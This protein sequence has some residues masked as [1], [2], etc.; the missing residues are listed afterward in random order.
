MNVSLRFWLFSLNFANIFSYVYPYFINNMNTFTWGFMICI[1]ISVFLN[2]YRCFIYYNNYQSLNI[3][4][5]ITYTFAFTCSTFLMIM[6]NYNKFNMSFFNYF[7]TIII[8]TLTY[9][10]TNSYKIINFQDIS[11]SSS[12][13]EC[14]I[15]LES[16]N[17]NFVKTSCNHSYHERCI[18]QW[19]TIKPNCPICREEF[20]I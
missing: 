8:N 13:I 7:F 2:F 14:V 20:K 11:Q 10:K 18:T 16:D 3:F 17:K 1:I 9:F 12:N 6:L 4:Q 15:C 19:L 5:V